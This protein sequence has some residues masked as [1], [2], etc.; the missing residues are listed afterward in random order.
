MYTVVYD[1]F[2]PTTFK[3][4]VCLKK[5]HVCLTCLIC[6]SNLYH[7]F[8]ILSNDLQIRSWQRN[9]LCIDE[10]C[11]LHARLV[12]WRSGFNFRHGGDPYICLG[13]PSLASLKGWCIDASLS[14]WWKFLHLSICLYAKSGSQWHHGLQTHLDWTLVICYIDKVQKYS[15]V[16]YCHINLP[17]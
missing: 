4:A 16:I 17:L 10:L 5:V 12:I 9:I 15:V 2:S 3:P 8:Y 1:V 6:N 14:W 11:L 7:H 13:Q